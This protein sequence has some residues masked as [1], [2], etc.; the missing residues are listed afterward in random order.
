MNILSA[1]PVHLTV[2]LVAKFL[3]LN[4]FP[5]SSLLMDQY[6]MTINKYLP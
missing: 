6:I 5:I 4:E 2:Y 3:L 1:R